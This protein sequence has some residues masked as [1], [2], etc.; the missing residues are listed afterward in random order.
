M[1]PPI[2]D[3]YRLEV[4]I[5]RDE[6]LEQW[7]ATDTTLDRPVLLRI[8]GPEAGEERRSRFLSAIRSAAR[9]NHPHLAA[10]FT[11]HETEHGMIAVAEWAGGMTI[12][13][14]IEAGQGVEPDDFLPN[15]AGLAEALDAL[16]EA[17]VVH[18]GIDTSA[19][20]YSVSHVA[21]LGALGRRQRHSTANGD[22]RDLGAALEEALTGSPAGGPPPSQVIDGLSPL[23]DRAL[24]RAQRGELTA[25]Q[26]SEAMHAAPTTRIPRPE[27]PG[28]SRRL[29]IIAIVLVALAVGLVAIGRLL[30]AGG[31]SPVLFPAGNQPSD[32]P[33]VVISTTTTAPPI[34]S[35]PATPAALPSIIEVT[36]IR[37]V[38]PFG[39]GEENDERLGNIV[40]GDLDTFWRTER[41]RDPIQLLKPGVGFAIELERNPVSVQITANNAG[42]LV[43]IAW[44]SSEVDPN[45]WETLAGVELPAGTLDLQLPERS[46]GT[47]VFWISELPLNGDQNYWVEITEVR[48]RS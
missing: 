30:L 7:L 23:V 40:D 42:A 24:R 18:G 27:R 19:I 47:W 4:R 15:A 8:L 35:N 22:V 16:H 14:R 13:D 28:S 1:P 33:R 36:S 29:L 2:P 34:S 11:A 12:A 6:D 32:Q 31:D 17:G 39:G 26:L 48:F 3:R 41:Y 44:T 20:Y 5:G 38:D 25:R 46:G 21:K 37:S 10:V 9:V 45:T 43:D